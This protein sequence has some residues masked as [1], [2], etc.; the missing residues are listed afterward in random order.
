M[1]VWVCWHAIKLMLHWDR[2]DLIWNFNRFI[3]L[4]LISCNFC[5]E[6][7]N[8]NSSK[9][10]LWVVFIS[11]WLIYFIL[12][13]FRNNS[14]SLT[15]FPSMFACC[16]GQFGVAF[17]WYWYFHSNIWCFFIPCFF[18]HHCGHKYPGEHPAAM[19][20]NSAE[21]RFTAQQPILLLPLVTATTG[22]GAALMMATITTIAIATNGILFEIRK[23]LK[24]FRK[25][26][27]SSS[28]LP[29]PSRPTFS[30]RVRRWNRLLLYV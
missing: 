30:V 8:Q 5:F 17:S 3:C 14:V 13:V 10:V 16:L 25:K 7:K 2:F 18:Y 1:S 4:S 27:I 11:I 24:Q 21:K 28:L 6:V 29:L 19:Q 22:T 9:H 20:H 23:V 15:N 26:L 12:A